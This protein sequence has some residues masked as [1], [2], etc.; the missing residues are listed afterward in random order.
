MKKI[1]II[2]AIVSCLI[3]LIFIGETYQVV[4]YRF[5]EQKVI[6]KEYRAKK[7]PDNEE[8]KF[9][10]DANNKWVTYNN[11]AYKVNKN[12]KFTVED[13]RDYDEYSKPEVEFSK[14]FDQAKVLDR[15]YNSK[16]IDKIINNFSISNSKSDIDKYKY[17]VQYIS[18]L[19]LNY[20]QKNPNKQ[21]KNIEKGYTACLGITWLQKQL[22]DKTDVCYKI[23]SF[24]PYNFENNDIDYSNNGHIFL[25]VKLDNKWYKSDMSDLISDISGE[26]I[27]YYGFVEEVM[28]SDVDFKDNYYGLTFNYIKNDKYKDVIQIV[29]PTMQNGKVVQNNGFNVKQRT[30]TFGEYIDRKI[31]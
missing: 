31:K 17:I 18:E 16:Y 6:I 21:I 12:K 10:K 20:S 29:S 15:K 4:P 22:L 11:R 2:L 5:P 25:Y 30:E 14:N 26:K 9:Y 23:V 27:P 28:E 8:I 13:L 1:L 24:R 7:E 19:N 3:G